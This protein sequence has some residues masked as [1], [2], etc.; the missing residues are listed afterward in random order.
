M[1]DQWKVSELRTAT[2]HGGVNSSC[3]CQQIDKSESLLSWGSQLMGFSPGS[4]RDQIQKL[5]DLKETLQLRDLPRPHEPSYDCSLLR[6]RH[7]HMSQRPPA[8]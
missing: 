6:R 7:P 8:V 5:Y 4:E 2:T 1:A 3:V